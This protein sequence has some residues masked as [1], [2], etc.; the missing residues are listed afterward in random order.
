MKS[1]E[2]KQ[3]EAIQRNTKS[4]AGH[5]LNLL[6]SE[7]QAASGVLPIGCTL[8]LEE[9]KALLKQRRNEFANKDLICMKIGVPK[10]DWETFQKS[11]DFGS[12]Y[13]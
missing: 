5:Y 12:I 8:T 6:A 3:K 13:C 11:S 9:Y 2:Q 4:M 1:K 10:K 7:K